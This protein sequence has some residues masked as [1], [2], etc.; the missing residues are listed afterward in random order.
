MTVGVGTGTVDVIA[1]RQIILPEHGANPP[2]SGANS[3]WLSG[4]Q[5]LWMSGTAI[6]SI[7]YAGLDISGAIS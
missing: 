6:V 4:G 7:G 5:L 1:P 2:L 3:L